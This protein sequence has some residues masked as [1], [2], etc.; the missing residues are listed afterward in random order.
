MGIVVS[1]CGREEEERGNEVGGKGVWDKYKKILMDQEMDY[2]EKK[3]KLSEVRSKMNYF[4]YSIQRTDL[5]YSDK[6]GELYMIEDGEK[7]FQN[8]RLNKMLL[9]GRDGTPDFL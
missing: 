2:S 4:T 8:G 3:Y 9:E 6:I 7:Y 5:I 1:L